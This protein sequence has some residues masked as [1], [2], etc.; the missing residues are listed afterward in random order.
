MRSKLPGIVLAPLA[1]LL[2]F[3]GVAVASSSRSSSF[4]HYKSDGYRPQLL[5]ADALPYTGSLLDLE[6]PARPVDADGVQLYDRD[7]ERFFHPVGMAQYGLAAVHGYQ[8]TGNPEYLRR[9]EANASKL[10]E[11]GVR[12]RG[13]MYFPYR[14]DF[15][16]HGDDDDVMSAP[17]YSAMA[18]GQALS[19]FV[20]L[21]EVT[22]E[23]R[24]REAADD[25]FLTFTLAR[26]TA[27]GEEPWTVFVDESRYLWLEEYAKDPPMRVLNGH[28]FAIYGLYDYHRLTGDHRAAELFDGAVTT[29]R[30]Y[31][32]DFRVPG[33][34]SFYCLRVRAQSEKYHR[35]HVGQLDTLSA[36]TGDAF[37]AEVT[38]AYARDVSAR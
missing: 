27:A 18:Q 15:R 4:P 14:F 12:A 25:A 11:E 20:R 23:E 7:G 6:D 34:V 1:V 19:L 37:F 13:A 32:D 29:I 35:T 21:L 5:D 8:E 33:D 30:H 36:L 3:A 2:L 22:G 17:W 26:E 38:D 10:I 24:W 9:A 16:L 31:A 28:I